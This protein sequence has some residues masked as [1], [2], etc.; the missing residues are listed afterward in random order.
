MHSVWLFSVLENWLGMVQRGHWK[1]DERTESW[2]A[3]KSGKE[4]TRR[5]GGRGT[6][7]QSSGEHACV[8]RMEPFIREILAMIEYNVRVKLPSTHGARV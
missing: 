6:L 1:V 2:Q 3:L 8:M 7:L 5:S 4:Q